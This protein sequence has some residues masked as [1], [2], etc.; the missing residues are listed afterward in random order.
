MGTAL[1]ISVV[2]PDLPDNYGE[3]SWKKLRESV[4]AVFNQHPISYILEELYQ[5]VE[6][7]C[8]HGMA[9]K[10]YQN[11]EEECRIHVQSIIPTF[12]QYPNLCKIYFVCVEGYLSLHSCGLRKLV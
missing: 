5:A 4:Q 9:T 2:K 10:L 6:N 7:M 3:E 1:K 8:S 12:Q 11:L